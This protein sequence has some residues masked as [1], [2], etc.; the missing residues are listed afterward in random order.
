MCLFDQSTTEVFKS[1]RDIQK[2]ALCVYYV[3]LS[4]KEKQQEIFQVH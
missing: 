2:W 3:F 4:L 1:R